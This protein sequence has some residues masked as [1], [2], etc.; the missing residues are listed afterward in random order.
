LF[1]T[2][3]VRPLT[4]V[5]ILW[6]AG[7]EFYPTPGVGRYQVSAG[8]VN[9]GQVA[10]VIW[11]ASLLINGMTESPQIPVGVVRAAE[12]FNRGESVSKGEMMGGLA[13]VADSDESGDDE[14]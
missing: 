3:F 1:V 5:R 2:D 9:G 14:G 7:P 12:Q 6:A 4:A 10:A 11:A 8:A 13:D